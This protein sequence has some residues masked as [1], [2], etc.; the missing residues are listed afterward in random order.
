V[1]EAETGLLDVV[2]I[3]I[4]G[5]ALALLVVVYLTITLRAKDRSFTGDKATDVDKY[6]V[7]IQEEIQRGARNFLK[8]EYSYLSGFVFVFLIVLVV[9]FGAKT[10]FEEGI[11]YGIC[12]LVGAILS[13]GAGW[14]GM[15]I[16]TDANVRTTHAA[17]AE[18]GGLNAAL[19]VA[20]AGGSVMGFTV[21]G[22]GIAGVVAMLSVMFAWSKDDKSNFETAKDSLTY[23]TGF[24]FGASSIAL[25]ARVAGG[26]YTKAADVGAD[27]V[28]KVEEDLP[29]DDPRNPAVIADNVGDNVGDVAGMGADLF[30]SYVGS[31]IAAGTLASDMK[32]LQLPFWIAGV[33]IL[34][35][36][37]GSRCVRT[38]DGANQEQLLKALGVGNWVASTLVIGASAGIVYHLFDNSDLGWKY[39]GCILI[40]LVSGMMIGYATEVC[41]SY[42]FSPTK[43]IAKAGQ[44]GS[45]TVIIQGL[46]VGMLSCLPPV[47][48]IVITIVACDKLGGGYGIAIAA[49]GMLA[50]LGVTLATDAYGPVA[51]N[52]G[53]IAEM[54]GLPDG[55]RNITDD[56]DALGN[57]TAATGKGFAIGSAVLT[58]LSLL[59]SFKSAASVQN[60]QLS[61]ADP[62]ILG[63]ILLGAV[64]PFVFAALTMLSVRKAATCI[65]L[66]VRRQ[67]K[68]NPKLKD[69]SYEGKPDYDECIRI[70]TASSVE[71]MILPGTY[72]ILA[73]I[74]V[75]LLVGPRCLGGLLSGSIASGFMMAVMMSNAGGAWD[76]AKKYIEIELKEKGTEMHKACVVGDT[77]GD[78]FKDTSGPALNILIKLMSMVSL[79]IAPLLEVEDWA[80]TGYGFIPLVVGL[81]ITVVVYNKYWKGFDEMF[82]KKMAEF[83]QMGAE[84]KPKDDS[85]AIITA[86]G[87]G[88]AEEQK[89]LQ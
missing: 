66:E 46:G 12:F 39:F 33:G 59:A 52:A 83:D 75:G 27:L 73:P 50:T 47:V 32:E 84:M 71:E 25:F 3:P 55:I 19:Q 28:G 67:F 58:A 31:I 43:S 15:I 18:Q 5:A 61:V 81:L 65:I 88:A 1:E 30:E 79:V 24:G 41:T 62:I 78:P 76:N 53:G 34:C 63:G 35:A 13:A 87:S 9:V 86:L 23:L 17:R 51:D 38:K 6:M 72:A 48:I 22:F 77:V 68:E 8:T 14:F 11:K 21:V 7:E 44:T 64:L 45:A 89:L 80:Q 16:A 26:I 49:V 74:T 56:L 70:S 2:L 82:D 37:I 40:G 10:T 4:I 85:A 42:A 54:A 57:T 60:D 29:E 36:I 20:F 69:L